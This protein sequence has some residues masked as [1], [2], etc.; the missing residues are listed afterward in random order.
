ML[1]ATLDRM[2]RNLGLLQPAEGTR[3]GDETEALEVA[4]QVRDIRI[5]GLLGLGVAF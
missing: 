3:P 5:S 4:A 2:G 1:N